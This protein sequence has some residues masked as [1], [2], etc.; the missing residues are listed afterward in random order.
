MVGKE[1]Y[2]T[3]ADQLSLTSEMPVTDTPIN[4]SRSVRHADDC[5]LRVRVKLDCVRVVR[6]A[7]LDPAGWRPLPDAGDSS[8]IVG[9]PADIQ[10]RR[11]QDSFLDELGMDALPRTGSAAGK[12]RHVGI[13]WPALGQL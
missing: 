6:W 10:A 5:H 12:A 8:G 1:G 2:G 4:V 13:N 9:D 3:D 11:S 7:D